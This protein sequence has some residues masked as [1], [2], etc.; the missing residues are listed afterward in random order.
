M[1]PSNHSVIL[2][3]SMDYMPGIVRLNA[4]ELS[5]P[6]TSPNDA[7]KMV[8]RLQMLSSLVLKDCD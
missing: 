8:V 6:L 7:M 4:Y 5:V 2:T 1:H 3:V